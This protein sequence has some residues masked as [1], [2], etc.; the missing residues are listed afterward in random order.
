MKDNR[1]LAGAAEEAPRD[2]LAGAA[3]DGAPAPPSKRQ[4]LE[5]AQSAALEEQIEVALPADDEARALDDGANE[6]D[7]LDDDMRDFYSVSAPVC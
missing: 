4:K 6:L 2:G 5:A 1:L 7:E 3:E